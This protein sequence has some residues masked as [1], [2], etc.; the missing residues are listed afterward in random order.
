[1]SRFEFQPLCF[2]WLHLHV[3]FYLLLNT[4]SIFIYF[5]FHF[6]PCLYVLHSPQLYLHQYLFLS[7]CPYVYLSFSIFLFLSPYVTLFVAISS[8]FNH[9]LFWFFFHVLVVVVCCWPI[10]CLNLPFCSKIAPKTLFVG[11]RLSLAFTHYKQFIR[12]MGKLQ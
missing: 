8:T 1:M 2:F 11:W 10:I 6:S 9:S 12:S 5:S 4:F 3:C 7:L